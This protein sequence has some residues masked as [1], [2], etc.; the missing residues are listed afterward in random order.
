MKGTK[1]SIL[2]II[3]MAAFVTKVHTFDAENPSIQIKNIQLKDIPKQIAIKGDLLIAKQ[4]NDNNGENLLIVSRK[5]TT[6]KADTTMYSDDTH[7]AELWCQQYIKKAEGY[8]L[9][10]KIYDSEMDCYF[11][12]WLGLLPNSTSIT[13]LDNNG[14]TETTLIY[15]STCRS[16]GSPSYMKLVMQ[17]ANDKMELRGWMF[18]PPDMRKKI[19]NNFEPNLSKID[20]TGLKHIALATALSGRYQNENDFNNAPAVFLQFARK[21]WLKYCEQDKFLQFNDYPPA[22]N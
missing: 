5:I 20:T 9:L 8:E 18:L 11:D 2:T 10:W 15:K 7:N 17:E 16:D 12:L 21:Q 6:N 13:D 3:L 14:I 19:T 22:S 1:L 4:W